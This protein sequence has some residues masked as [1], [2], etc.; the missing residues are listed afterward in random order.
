VLGRF[1]HEEQA[2]WGSPC[3]M[4]DGVESWVEGEHRRWRG[5]V[6]LFGGVD[7]REG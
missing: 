1:D 2:G 5:Q 6:V 4:V 3:T 7:L